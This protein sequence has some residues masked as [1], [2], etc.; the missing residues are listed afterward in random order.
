MILYLAGNPGHGKAGK[1]RTE[2][3]NSNRI[4]RVI[5]FFWCKKGASFNNYFIRTKEA[6]DEIMFRRRRDNR[7]SS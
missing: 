1:E 7:R 5:S 3:L 2:F 6:K 4:A